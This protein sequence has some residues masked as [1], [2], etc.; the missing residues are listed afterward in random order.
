M[1]NAFTLQKHIEFSETDAAGLLHFAN[2]FRFME[3]TEHKFLRALNIEVMALPGQQR[4]GWPKVHAECDYHQP[5]YFNDLLDIELTVGAYSSRSVTY[6]FRFIKINMEPPTKV[7]SGKLIVT[8]AQWRDD[9]NQL[10]TLTIPPAIT[11]KISSFC[12]S[13]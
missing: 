2:F 13:Q 4:R 10:E 8:H 11:A 5:V 9:E 1:S 6:E 12:V 3:M 7:A